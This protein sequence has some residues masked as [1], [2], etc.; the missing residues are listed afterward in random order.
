LWT[1]L[2][3]IALA[4]AAEARGLIIGI[5]LDKKAIRMEARHIR[6]VCD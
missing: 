3:L 2:V 1:S 5:E 6:I 4:S